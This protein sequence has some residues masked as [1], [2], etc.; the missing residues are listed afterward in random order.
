MAAATGMNR[1]ENPHVLM[2]GMGGAAVVLPVATAARR[3]RTKAV[4]T[5]P[6]DHHSTTG[7]RY[8]PNTSFSAA[9]ISPNVAWAFTA[10]IR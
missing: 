10:S 9:Q 7:S 8:V 6:A 5:T 1:S 4:S 3:V 2:W